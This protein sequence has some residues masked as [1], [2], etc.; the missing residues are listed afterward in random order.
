MPVFEF[1]E[2]RQ[3]V[4]A[5]EQ[6]VDLAARQQRQLRTFD[7]ALALPDEHEAGA[8][9]FERRLHGGLVRA[10]C[11]EAIDVRTGKQLVTHDL[12]MPNTVR[13]H[14]KRS[15]TKKPRWRNGVQDPIGLRG[16]TRWMADTIASSP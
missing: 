2:Q 6:L 9:I 10:Q 16:E 11:A 5:G 4:A 3:I 7:Q 12:T 1:A 14:K 8:R 15:A 13:L